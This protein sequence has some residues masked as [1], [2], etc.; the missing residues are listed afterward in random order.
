MK[1]TNPAR[2]GVF[3]APPQK[4]MEAI[5]NSIGFDYPLAP[6][7]V[8]VGK[9]HIQSLYERGLITKQEAAKLKGGLAKIE[10]EV[11]QN[12]FPYRQE[13]EDI[14]MNIE[15]R[16]GE[17]VGSVAQKFHS[18]RSRND[19]VA[20]DLRMWLKD[21]ATAINKSLATL[22]KVL[23]DQALAHK[24][25]VMP[26]FTHLQPAAVITLGSHLLAYAQML[27]RDRKRLEAVV[28]RCDQCPMGAA[29]L[30]GSLLASKRSV[31][32]K[33]LGFS[34][35]VAN[36]LDAVSSRD[37]ALEFLSTAAISG[38]NLSRLGEEIVLWASPA[39]G[40]ISLSDEWATGSS[41]LPQKKNP[42][43]AELLRAKAAVLLANFAALGGVMKGLPLAYSKDLQEDKPPIF[44]TAHNWQLM[45]KATAQMLG[46]ATFNKKAMLEATSKGYVLAIDIAE[47]LV[48]LKGIPFRKAHKLVGSLVAVAMK[49]NCSLEELSLSQIQRVIPEVD[50]AFLKEISIAAALKNRKLCSGDAVVREARQLTKE[51]RLK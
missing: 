38:V 41:I 49:Q 37:F 25:T 30:A 29:A 15:A 21:A 26:A 45:V 5:N 27:G 48:E 47:Q 44:A 51:W 36:P 28:E 10:K 13:F 20:T 9:V 1:R 3:T 16:L 2:S 24:D 42:D 35:P 32:A 14:H 39:F 6:Q 40:F 7:E 4:T 31:T 22:Q 46:S 12:K 17:L 43:A 23:V 11:S 8:K 34:K 33:R 19:L 18:G 50:E